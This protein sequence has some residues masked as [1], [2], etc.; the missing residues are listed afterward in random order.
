MHGAP[1]LAPGASL[2]Y[3][4]PGAPKGGRLVL[5]ELGGFD[6]LNPFILKGRAPWVLR[7]HVAETLLARSWDEPFT[8]YGLLA[9]SVETP[10]DR[11]W[12]VFR[13]RPEARFSDGS[14]VT[15][16][17][18]IWSF[19][20]LAAEGHPRYRAAWD[21]VS[22]IEA[23]GA[24]SVRITFSE[25]N[26]ELPLIMGLR[27]VLKKAAFEGRAFAEPG[28]VPV[29]GSGPYVPESWEAGRQ[30]TLRRD[31]DWWG[32]GLPINAGLYNFDT[33]RIEYFRNTDALFS[34]LATGALS[35]FHDTD[36]LR[37]AEGYDGLPAVRDG[38]LRRHV[39]P[40]GRP[41]GMEGFVFNTRREVFADRR[42][43]EALALAFDWDWVNARLF[44]GQYARIESYWSGSELGWQGAATGR[45]A[46]LLAP[47]AAALPE[48][49]LE[50]GWRPPAG[51]GRRNR[52]GLRRASALLE[53]AGWEL[54]GDTRMRGGAPLAFEILVTSGEAETLGGLWA[55][56]LKRLG[57]AATVRRVD[58]AQYE[59]RRRDYDYD[60][61]VNRWWLSLSPGTEQWLYF[62]P[63]GRQR[64]GTRNYMGVE[65]PAVAAM[66]RAILAAE[67]R[68]G[69]VAAVRALDRVLS[70]GIY[71][72]PFGHLPED[73]VA[74][75][76]GYARP[77]RAPLYGFRPEVWWW[78]PE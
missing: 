13:L 71:V 34:A 60:V 5:G 43:R 78:Q 49:T 33:L 69:F 42:V 9:E 64:P 41:S 10:A 48:G 39:I 47:F 12:V 51:D 19:E 24:R 11:S 36:P 53:A 25:P 29:I 22:A 46:A 61:I 6:S 62:G 21:A 55:G 63:E 18:V 54:A 65:A 66:I 52:R 4:A 59:A 73:R 14:P 37:W 35:L 68:E 31:P 32:A 75:Q 15:V 2:P 77:E 16:E 76:A 40:H 57:V 28:L 23:V 1:A 20:T 3:A 27:P 50:R 38:R 58:A 26:R 70:A 74:A 8:L 72:V 17:D 30:L 44:A 67:R 56:A 7:T 45:E